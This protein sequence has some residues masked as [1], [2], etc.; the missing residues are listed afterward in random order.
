MNAGSGG[1]AQD[2]DRGATKPLCKFWKSEE[3]CRRGQDCN[4]GH[5]I[6]DMKGR[7]VGCGATSHIKKECPTRK[8]GDG[9]GVGKDAK[10]AAKLKS[11]KE[12][13]VNEG[14]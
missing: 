3:G 2:G 6:A 14:R 4:H 11:G 10:R 1:G 7:C 9:N 13:P 8:P 5:D 12:P